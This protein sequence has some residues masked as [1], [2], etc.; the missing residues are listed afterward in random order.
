MLFT[1]ILSILTAF[2]AILGGPVWVVPGL[3]DQEAR[4]VLFYLVMVYAML[5]YPFIPALVFVGLFGLFWDFLWSTLVL[6]PEAER[7]AVIIPPLGS[8]PFILGLMTALLHVFTIPQ[9]RLR[10]YTYTLGV[11]I[12]IP[13]LLTAEYLFVSVRSGN[14]EFPFTFLQAEIWFL[15]LRSTAVA[16]IIAPLAYLLLQGLERVFRSRYAR[17]EEEY[18]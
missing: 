2:L 17:L 5:R 10:W 1:V 4:L 13:S 18:P 6:F 12:T 11:L 16:F 7:S 14:F 9:R 8:T 15:I 3:Q